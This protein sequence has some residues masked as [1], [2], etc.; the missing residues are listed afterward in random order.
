M[1][2]STDSSSGTLSL[3]A[4]NSS[5]GSDMTRHTLLHGI[6]CLHSMLDGQ[7]RKATGQRQLSPTY[8]AI[9][10]NVSHH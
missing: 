5:R 10:A 7:P 1:V 3:Q 2:I 8:K 4:T 6:C 9:Q